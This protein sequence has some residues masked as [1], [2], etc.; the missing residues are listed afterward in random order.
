[1]KTVFLIEAVP[2]WFR[3]AEPV[4]KKIECQELLDDVILNL[5]MGNWCIKHY[6]KSVFNNSFLTLDF[7][8]Y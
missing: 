8:F 1:M 2:I 7:T 5:D 3:N 4:K 6:W